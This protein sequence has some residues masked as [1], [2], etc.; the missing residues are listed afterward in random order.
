MSDQGSGI[1]MKRSGRGIGGMI[2]AAAL[3]LASGRAAAQGAVVVGG[4]DLSRVT[5]QTLAA[6]VARDL[7]TREEA[8]SL[9]AKIAKTAGADPLVAAVPVVEAYAAMAD[10]LVGKGAITRAEADG[11][12]KAAAAA[13]GLKAGGLNPVVLAASW[14]DLIAKKGI[15]SLEQAQQTLDAARLR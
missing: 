9:E 5:A 13:P 14:L 4:Y 7:M 11:A 12:R 15:I 3:M 1:G 8:A 6:L 2:V 10:R